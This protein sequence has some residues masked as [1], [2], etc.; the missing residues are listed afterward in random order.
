VELFA[1]HAHLP[2][3]M[4]ATLAAGAAYVPLDPSYPSDVLRR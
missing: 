1:A 2:I 4:L 3:A